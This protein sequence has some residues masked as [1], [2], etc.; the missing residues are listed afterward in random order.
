V[1]TQL[2]SGTF[3]CVLETLTPLTIK[4]HFLDLKKSNKPA[5]I[6]GSSVKGMVRNVAEILGAGCTLYFGSA[7]PK[8]PISPCA[9]GAA[10][11]VCRVFGYAPPKQEGG[12]QAKARFYDTEL[13]RPP[14]WI[15]SFIAS[16]RR[17]GQG[18]YSAVEQP[19]HAEGWKIFLHTADAG[20]YGSG[21]AVPSV[22]KGALFP[23][24]VKFENLD[25]EE[26]A[27]LRFCISLQHHCLE[28]GTF[29]LCHKLGYGKSLGMG[30]CNIRI[31]ET[32]WE[33]PGRYFGTTV[34]GKHLETQPCV[35]TKY[36]SPPV[37][38]KIREFLSW[39][40]AKVSHAVTHQSMQP[41]AIRPV[42]D[43]E[44]PQPGSSARRITIAELAATKQP[45][46]T[47]LVR[48]KTVLVRITDFR[49]N[50]ALCE[51]LEEFAGIKY[52]SEFKTPYGAKQGDVYSVKVDDV[53]DK[54]H[55]FNA[56]QPKLQ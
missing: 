54:K 50:Q 30:S 48:N 36:F 47:G 14:E 25:E 21:A 43:E 39:E 16:K 2:Y 28:H 12:W 44:N 33:V 22:P 26:F 45:K 10:C 56:R 46:R 18:Q 6:P 17:S 24:R 11:L 49:G 31:V 9:A 3:Q 40:P 7:A 52:R 20:G 19:D 5:W 37:F 41:P 27:V 15:S 42:H 23:F 8:P 32:E 4:Q 13:V 53:N 29:H 35:L 1:R 34:A 55:T 38:P 51:T